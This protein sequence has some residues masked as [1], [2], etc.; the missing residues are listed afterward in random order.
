MRVLAT[1]S[2]RQFPLHFPSRASPCATRFRTSSTT[3]LC[4]PVQRQVFYPISGTFGFSQHTFVDVDLDSVPDRKGI[5][6]LSKEP[7]PTLGSFQPSIKRVPAFF[8]TG[9]IAGA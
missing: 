4:V 2:I 6:L 8:P 7:R 5:F 9:K 3:H 1:L